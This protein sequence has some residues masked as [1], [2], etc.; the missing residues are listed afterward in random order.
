MRVLQ[1]HGKRGGVSKG[2]AVKVREINIERGSPT[3][4]EAMR[5]MV[6]ELSTAKGAGYRA[7]V[8][9]H[10]YGSSGTGGAI[11]A[12]VK[13]KLNER[14]LSGMVRDY[15]Q[16]EE[17]VNRKRDFMEACSQLKDYDRHVSG[18]RGVTVILLK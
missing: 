10:G 4:E 3:V 7:V 6:N 14:S 13:Q 15:A 5:R 9:V 8:L 2:I 12:A 17:W 18:N 11:K 16:G 1:W